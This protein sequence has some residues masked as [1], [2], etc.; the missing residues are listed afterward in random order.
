VK[1]HPLERRYKRLA[2]GANRKAERLGAVGRITEMDLALIYQFS[3]GFCAYCG[4]GVE[5]TENSFDHIVPFGSGGSNTPDN[6][7]V[8]CMTCQRQKFTKTPDE[9]ER[10][11]VLELICPVDGTRFRPRWADYQRGL[12]KYCSRR[13]SGAVGGAA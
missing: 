11:K 13:C 6:I 8:C 1:Q 4:I 12:G 9:Y 7:T 10:W 5:P 2:V 3:G